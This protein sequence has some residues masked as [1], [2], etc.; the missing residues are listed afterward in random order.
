MEEELLRSIVAGAASGS[1]I[2]AILGLVFHQRKATIENA[3]KH[4][5]AET[6]EEFKS[7]RGWKEESLAE[8]IAPVVMHLGRTSTVSDRYSVQTFKKAG[9]S[10]ADAQ[11]MRESNEAVRMILLSKGHLLPEELRETAHVLI[12]HYDEWLIRFDTTLRNVESATTSK[13]DVGFPNVDFPDD[14]G[15]AFQ[16]AYDRLRAELYD[17]KIEKRDPA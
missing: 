2:A 3:V 1:V 8:L 17:F 16:A 5:F 14:A 7:K 13:F 15:N 11:I 9:V 10:Y 12:A 6:L 4:Q